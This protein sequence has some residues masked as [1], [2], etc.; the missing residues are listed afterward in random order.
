MAS[1]N[2]Q[3]KIKITTEYCNIFRIIQCDYDKRMYMFDCCKKNKIMNLRGCEI[4]R[5]K[6]NDFQIDV[7]EERDEYD[8]LVEYVQCQLIGKILRLANT[9]ELVKNYS[10][11]QLI[12]DV[13]EI[14]SKKLDT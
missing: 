14:L 4:M 6:F 10:E 5:A 9:F 8:A 11:K 13:C 3:S 7:G 12:S 2:N 1:D